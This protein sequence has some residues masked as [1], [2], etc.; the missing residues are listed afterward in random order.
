MTTDT[1]IVVAD[2]TVSLD[3]YV[4]GPRVSVERP[5]GDGGELLVWYGDDVNDPDADLSAVHDDVDARV[6]EEAGAR[7]GA[8]IMGRTT[9]DVSIDAWGD[10]P[11]IRKPCFVVTSRPAPRVERR[12]GTSFTFVGSPS[13]ALREARRV[14]EGR[15]V[16][17]MGGAATVRGFLD[18]GLIDELHLHVVPVLLGR[19]V[20]LFEELADRPLRLEKVHALDGAKA[21]HLAF[22]P[23]RDGAVQDQGPGGSA[24]STR[25]R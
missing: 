6:L 4:A 20:R 24:R 3:G 11:P 13:E 16:V 17:V 12:G 18:A 19:G 23:Q 2:I 15:D 22:R 1:G 21:V 25:T 10:E 5:H 14:A 7:E 9:F 8:V